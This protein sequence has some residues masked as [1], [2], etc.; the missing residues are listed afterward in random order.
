MSSR[1]LLVVFL[2]LL[3]SFGAIGSC[4][5]NNN[6]GGNGNID[7]PDFLE[8]FNLEIAIELAELALVA[9]EQRI[10][11][12]N[13][14][15]GAITVPSPY[16]LEEVI[17]EEVSS[18]FNS[19]CLDDDSVIPIA[20]IA[21]ENENIYVSFRGTSNVTDAVDDIATIQ[22][23]YTFVSNGGNVALGFLDVYNEIESEILNKVNELA[24]TGNFEN[25]FI[26]GHSLGAALA[27]LAFPD[28]SQNAGPLDSVSMYN[29]AGPAVGDSQFVSTYQGIESLNRISFR[30][31][32]T[33]DLVP[34]LPPQGLDCFLFSYEHVGG[35]Q[36]I[37]FGIMLPPLPD[38]ANDD[39]DLVTIAEQITTYGL[40]NADGILE[41]HSMC[42]YF[43]TLCNMG[44]DPS[45]CSQRAIGCNDGN[46]N[47]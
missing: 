12:I 43:S 34:K 24:M 14:G 47:P 18:F 10:Q 37:T 46:P 27:F 21:T 7:D 11:C 13:S 33:N 28:F 20:F 31:V 9:Y 15:K 16:T 19:T 8:G 45:S 23:P 1:K 5:N 39:C 35:R 3:V 2:C 38:F 6:G 17:F 29:F 42:T 4:N 26:T 36:D 40:N 41:N 44:S 30:V 25:L 32:N 22:T